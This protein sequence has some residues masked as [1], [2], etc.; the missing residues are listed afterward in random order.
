MEF[1][2]IRTHKILC[3]VIAISECAVE[4]IKK[5]ESPPYRKENETIDVERWGLIVGA[6]LHMR[7]I[8][9]PMELK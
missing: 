4:F 8:E 9:V 2:G 7:L 5:E 6:L 3:P 1:I